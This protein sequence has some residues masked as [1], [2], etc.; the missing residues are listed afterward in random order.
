MVE[1]R[2]LVLWQVHVTRLTGLFI[3]EQPIKSLDCNFS[4]EYICGWTNNYAKRDILKY[5]NAISDW[6]RIKMG[7]GG[8]M[9]EMKHIWSATLLVYSWIMVKICIYVFV[10]H[11]SMCDTTGVS[12][13]TFWIVLAEWLYVWTS[14]SSSPNVTDSWNASR[15]TRT[16]ASQDQSYWW[17][18]P[19][20]RQ[21]INSSDRKLVYQGFPVSA[22]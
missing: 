3:A 14:R 17:V 1:R 5:N 4:D 7:I 13:L 8:M 2:W 9:L 19:L 12:N 6:T 22:E 15:K 16:I 11:C 20:G 21:L 18:G 10:Y